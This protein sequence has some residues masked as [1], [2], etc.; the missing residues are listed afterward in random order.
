MFGAIVRKRN[1]HTDAEQLDAPPSSGRQR[2]LVHYHN[3]SPAGADT[4]AKESREPGE[5][6]EPGKT[7]SS[8]D[9][10][11]GVRKRL[12]NVMNRA[13]QAT[14]HLSRE[15][16]IRNAKAEVLAFMHMLRDFD[17]K[18]DKLQKVEAIYQ[19]LL[20]KD[21][22]EFVD[23][24]QNI[25]EETCCICA[26]EDFFSSTKKFYGFVRLPCNACTKGPPMHVS[27]FVNLI[28]TE[29]RD[30][31]YVRCPYCRTMFL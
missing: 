5:P 1:M 4:Q 10:F 15:E 28:R 17:V 22:E 7:A 13:V 30:H 26:E 19:K 20:G 6:G 14:P 27:C 9:T 8:P 12:V 25:L 23:E 18:L 3:P 24:L 31:G 16:A 11:T 21:G 2:A 29:M